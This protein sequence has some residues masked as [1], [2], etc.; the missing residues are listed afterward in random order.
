MKFVRP[1]KDVSLMQE[2]ILVAVDTETT[3]LQ[4]GFH[5]LVEIAAV[6]FRGNEILDKFESLINPERDIPQEVIDIHG[7][8]SDMVKDAPY[9]IEVVP[10][11]I[12]FSEDHPLIAHNAP[13]DESFISFN[14]HG[15]CGEEPANSIYDTL[16]LTRKLFP[17]L[18][19]HSLANLATYLD[20]DDLPA[21]RAMADVLATV[22]VFNQCVQRMRGLNVR[23]W[24]EFKEYYGHPHYFNFEKYDIAE[25]LPE[26]FKGILN[27]I[28][29]SQMMYI[30][31]VANNSQPSKRVIVPESI[32]LRDGNF[33]LN[34]FC[35]LRHENRLFRLDR[36][37]KFETLA[38]GAVM[39][40]F[41]MDG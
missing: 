21:H 7:I 24:A 4:P 10:E 26:E 16:I 36:I 20:V 29:N 22:G 23:T 1:W 18:R 37:E 11:F 9:A 19:S 2:Q 32:F 17:E 35:H 30:E 27:V 40:G 31:Y 41:E 15:Q 39:D 5:Q 34:A 14:L 25:E 6:K 33:Y 8:T 12:Q 3:G 38:K 28:E 13:F